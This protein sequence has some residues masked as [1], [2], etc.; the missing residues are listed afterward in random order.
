MG[1]HEFEGAFGDD[2][3]YPMIDA[4]RKREEEEPLRIAYG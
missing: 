1:M 3:L 2:I 4:A